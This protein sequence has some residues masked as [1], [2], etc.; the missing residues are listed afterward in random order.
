MS[1]KDVKPKAKG[2]APV[3]NPAVPQQEPESIKNS[4]GPAPYTLPKE[5]E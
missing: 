5:S 2:P 4:K 3:T 1:T